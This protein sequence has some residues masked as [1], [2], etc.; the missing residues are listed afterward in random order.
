MALRHRD[1]AFRRVGADH[2]RAEPRQRLG[3]DA[4]AAA[5]IENPQAGETVETARITAEM[6]GGAVAD[7]RRDEPD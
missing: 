6:R 4:A 5:D 1:V 3:Q 2:R 7:I